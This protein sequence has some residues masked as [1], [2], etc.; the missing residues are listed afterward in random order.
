V[1]NDTGHGVGLTIYGPDGS[2]AVRD[3][4]VAPANAY[5][6]DLPDSTSYEVIADNQYA[7]YGPEWVYLGTVDRYVNVSALN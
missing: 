6:V 7:T 2:V 4:Y 3:A 1:Y 5:W